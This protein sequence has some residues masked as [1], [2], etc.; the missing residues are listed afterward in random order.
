M[1][2]TL[3]FAHPTL[4]VAGDDNEEYIPVAKTCVTPAKAG[5]QFRVSRV[6]RVSRELDTGF[7][8]YDE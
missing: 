4:V 2:G 8:R 5:V 6:S 3:R 7:R 1:V